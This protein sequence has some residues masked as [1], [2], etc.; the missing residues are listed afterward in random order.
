MNISCTSKQEL[1]PLIH[2]NKLSVVLQDLNVDG[3]L[4]SGLLL[5]N[6]V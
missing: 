4:Q 6:Y 2:L 1:D 5:L 3:S